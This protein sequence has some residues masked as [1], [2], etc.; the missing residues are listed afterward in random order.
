MAQGAIANSGRFGF[1]Y[2]TGPDNVFNFCRPAAALSRAESVVAD[3][4]VEERVPDT[5]GNAVRCLGL[6]SNV[7]AAQFSIHPQPSREKSSAV[8]R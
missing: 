5:A 2:R 3:M 4:G 8:L 1:S 6:A 7:T